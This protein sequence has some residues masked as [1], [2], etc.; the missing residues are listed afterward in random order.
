[1]KL[2]KRLLGVAASLFL[3]CGIASSQTDEVVKELNNRGFW[4]PYV[5]WLQSDDR[6]ESFL[7]DMGEK[8]RGS[9]QRTLASLDDDHERAQ[10]LLKARKEI[11]GKKKGKKMEE[12]LASRF[13]NV[14]A[15]KRAF[16]AAEQAEVRYE[17]LSR[18][19]K[20]ELNHRKPPVMPA[21]QLLC[22]RYSTGN[23]FGGY[24]FEVVLDGRKGKHELKVEEKRMRWGRPEGEEEKAV[25]P[26]EVDDSV[27]QR[28]RDMVEQGQVYDIGRYYMPDYDITDASNWSLDITFEQGSVSSGGYADGPDH[29][30]TL[31]AITK[32]L[33]SVFKALP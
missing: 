12:R 19:I 6:M 20:Y 8:G 25:V 3:G 11:C 23:A 28:V 32:Y 2:K 9:L 17:R 16:E 4:I 10:K 22:F 27:F 5:T 14:E 30:D 26:K 24:H 29:H 33:T 15:A 31:N 7:R 13:E 1:M 21:G 18:A